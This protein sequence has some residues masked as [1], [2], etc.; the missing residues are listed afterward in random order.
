MVT[1]RQIVVLFAFT[2][3]ISL[4]IVLHNKTE[5]FATYILVAKIVLIIYSFEFYKQN[6][7]KFFTNIVY[8]LLFFSIISNVV[9]VLINAGIALPTYQVANTNTY[10]LLNAG[11]SVDVARGLG[12]VR[13][14]GVFYEPGLYQFILSISC[15]WC[16][17]IKKNKL[18]YYFFVTLI[19]TFSIIGFV[20]ALFVGWFY[21]LKFRPALKYL[22]ITLSFIIFIASLGVIENVINLKSET[23]SYFL[24]S[25]DLAEGLQLFFEQ[26]FG[27]Y[28]PSY[29][30]KSDFNQT[31][32]GNSNGIFGLLHQFGLTGLIY[33]IWFII[34][35]ILKKR[36]LIVLVVL[37]TLF[38]QNIFQ[39]D[40]FLTIFIFLLLDKKITKKFSNF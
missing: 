14:T 36:K 31:L 2:L 32:R 4:L 29:F 34:A 22:A 12:L 8:A 19:S 35:G 38:S 26:P 24:R 25:S 1:I 7:D 37:T 17:R 15:I 6:L 13:N 39:S 23:D 40:F 9:Y 10:L 3:P 20:N 28:G 30:A 27:G 33:L 21:I 5:S 11:Y 16:I 18:F